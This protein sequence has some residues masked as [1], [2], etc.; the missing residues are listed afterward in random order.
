MLDANS[1]VYNLKI[2]QCGDYIEVYKYDRCSIKGNRSKKKRKEK[3]VIERT[4]YEKLEIKK[5][6]VNAAKN[7]LARLIKSNPDMTTFLT[8]TFAEEPTIAD[9]KKLL[10][11]CFSKIRRKFKNFKYLWVVEFGEKNHRLHYHVLCNF[12]LPVDIDFTNTSRRKKEA[13]KLYELEFKNRYWNYGWVD[14][15]S[16]SAER[17]SNIAGYISSYLTK[18]S[19]TLELVDQQIYNHS[20]NLRKPCID[21]Y[22]SHDDVEDILQFT[23]LYDLA[24][25]NSYDYFKDGKVNYFSFREKGCNYDT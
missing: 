17:I 24:Y 15:R 4:D 3:T 25:S 21:T 18:D 8:L 11:V 19:Y 13:H 22:L 2:I 6:N 20:R 10:N 14:V 9:S 16:L 5:K 23:K 1:D 7:K 12:L